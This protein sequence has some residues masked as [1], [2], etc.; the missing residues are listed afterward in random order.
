M[1]IH[2]DVRARRSI[3]IHHS[4]WM[5]T[6]EPVTEPPVRLAKA[7]KAIGLRD[8]EFDTLPTIGA[9]AVVDV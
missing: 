3:S 1:L 9:T 4:A 8:G 5:L 2:R 7:A 6:D